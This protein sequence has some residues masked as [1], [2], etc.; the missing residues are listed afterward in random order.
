MTKN[1]ILKN[2]TILITGGT[3]SWAYELVKQLLRDHEPKEIRLYSR[4]ELRQVDMKR[5]YQDSRLKFIIGDVRD[6]SRLLLACENVDYVIHLAA[7]KHVP[8]C[9]EN[10]YEAVKTNIIGTENVIEA[11]IENKVKKVLDVSTD[12]ACDPLN[13][14][15]LTKSCGERL[16]ISAN[17]ISPH[18]KFACIR[19]GNVLGTNGSVVPLFK[20]QILKL[21]EVTITEKNMTRFFMRVEQAIALVLNTLL[22]FQGGEIFVTK[23][24]ACNILDLAK[25]MIEQFGNKQ[26]KISY[27]GIRPGEKIHEVLI[28]KYES[29]RT[30]SYGDYYVILPHIDLSETLYFYKNLKLKPLNLEEYTSNSVKFLKDQEIYNLLKTDG[31]F[32]E[33]DIRQS[34]VNLKNLD[35]KL[36]K[37]Y[38]K[39]EGWVEK[40]R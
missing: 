33:K 20:E 29:S 1:N 15:G 22:S 34:S 30:F 14:Y 31:W 12:K 35:K 7:L 16:A 39:S 28:S 40:K 10:A 25:V 37:N 5:H 38:Y 23:M 8:V 21:N 13:L 4:N 18:T 24:P 17:T 9:E 26:T 36:L 11:A 32:E 27:I 19:A 3:G 6:K 2:S